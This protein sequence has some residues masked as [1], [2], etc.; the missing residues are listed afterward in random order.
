MFEQEVCAWLRLNSRTSASDEDSELLAKEV[1]NHCERHLID[2]QVPRRIKF[3]DAFPQSNGGKYLR[4]EM[5][6]RFKQEL[7][8]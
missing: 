6:K 7:N 2:Y 3:V 5:S 1:I 8:I 4:T